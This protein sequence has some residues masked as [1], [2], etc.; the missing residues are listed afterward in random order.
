MGTWHV[1]LH[2]I[3]WP[4]YHFECCVALCC[5]CSLR[6]NRLKRFT[7]LTSW[8]YVKSS[9]TSGSRARLLVHTIEHLLWWIFVW[10]E[11]FVSWN[12]IEGTWSCVRPC[13]ICV[14]TRNACCRR[15]EPFQH[16]NFQ[17]EKAKNKLSCW[18]AT[19]TSHINITENLLKLH[20]GRW[21]LCEL[22]KKNEEVLKELERASEEYKSCL[23]LEGLQEHL[24]LT[25]NAIERANLSRKHWNFDKQRESKLP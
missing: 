17:K 13:A 1:A 21:K 23:E 25:E 8:N 22:A 2:M 24:M 15:A 12:V 14:W 9:W 4:L 6:I 7:I 16:W 18:K 11:E 20:G 3:D 19:L 10:Y 5:C